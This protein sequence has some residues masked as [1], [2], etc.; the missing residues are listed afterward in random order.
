MGPENSIHMHRQA[1]I[2]GCDVLEFDVR[3]TKDN[4][5]VVHHDPNVDRTSNFKGEVASFTY[6]QLQLV[7]SAHQYTPKGPGKGPYLIQDFPFRGQGYHIPLFSTFMDAFEDNYKNIEIKDNVPLAA[8]LVWQEIQRKHSNDF[9]KV[10]VASGHCDVLNH[11]RRVSGGMVATSACEKEGL[12]FFLMQNLGLGNFWFW[13]FP[14]VAVAYQAPVMS[15]GVWLNFKHFVDAAH[16]LNQKLMY[17]VINDGQ[18]AHELLDLGADGIVSD[19]ADLIY[20]TFFERGI[21][22]TSLQDRLK[23]ITVNSTDSFFIPESNPREIHTCLSLGCKVLPLLMNHIPEIIGC[24][25]FLFVFIFIRAAP[26]SSLP[27]TSPQSIK[28]STPKRKKD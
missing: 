11:F 23:G 7:D 26:S 14:P 16:A 17:W 5:L 13:L 25:V 10:I 1:L 15:S 6:E 9:S 2:M 4:R 27:P 19:R 18:L 21:T 20:Q 3:L 24:L 12:A 8:E 22:Q 28:N